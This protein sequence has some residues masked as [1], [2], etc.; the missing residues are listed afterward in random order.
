M[1]FASGTPALSP[2]IGAHGRRR[3]YQ[4]AA[5][6]K[7]RQRNMIYRPR[8]LHHVIITA[9]QPRR[10]QAILVKAVVWLTDMLAVFMPIR[11]E[12]CSGDDGEKFLRQAW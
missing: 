5:G 11:K 4:S 7:W 2:S 1:S 9:S 12:L 6:A 10:N 3:Q 8:W